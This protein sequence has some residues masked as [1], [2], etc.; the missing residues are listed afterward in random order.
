MTM[1]INV[2]RPRS[3]SVGL[4]GFDYGGAAGAVA[5]LVGVEAG[6]V[7][8]RGHHWRHRLVRSGAAGQVS[9]NRA[10]GHLAK[11]RRQIE[12]ADGTRESAVLRPSEQVLQRGR[13]VAAARGYQERGEA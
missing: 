5:G 13:I 9:A 6:R 7:H 4:A 1:M 12:R 10:G 8:E 3:W 2:P 11:L